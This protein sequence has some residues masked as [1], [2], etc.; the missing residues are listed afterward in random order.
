MGETSDTVPLRF[1]N[2]SWPDEG[3]LDG[4]RRVGGGIA[5]QRQQQLAFAQAGAD[6]LPGHERRPDGRL[7]RQLDL[8]MLPAVV[9]DA[10]RQLGHHLA[11]IG[12][13]GR[14]PGVVNQGL[15]HFGLVVAPG[16]QRQLVAGAQV[17]IRQHRRGVRPARPRRQLAHVDLAE[18]L[19][20]WIGR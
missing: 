15:Q 11:V 5:F 16:L 1:G 20:G 19:A 12:D 6:R 3:Q 9:A 18:Q 7:L 2:L 4:D 14:Q 10:Q 13:H 8:Q 17:T